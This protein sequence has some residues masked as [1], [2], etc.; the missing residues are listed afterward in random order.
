MSMN[1]GNPECTEGLSSELFAAMDTSFDGPPELVAINIAATKRL[2]WSLASTLVAH[3][4]ANGEAVVSASHNGLQ[5]YLSPAGTP[6]PTSPGLP[7]LPDGNV[8]VLRIR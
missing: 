8:A 4:S 2:C 6:T 1:A 3:I 5:T 7:S